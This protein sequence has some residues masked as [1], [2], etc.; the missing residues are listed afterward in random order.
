MKKTTSKKI[1]MKNQLLK[2]LKNVQL[3]FIY[4]EIDFNLHNYSLLRTKNIIKI[5]FFITFK[6]N[7]L[8]PQY[9]TPIYQLIIDITKIISTAST[10]NLKT[11]IYKYKQK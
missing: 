10:K 7:K 1:V 5:F 2:K 6:T 8:T 9:K 11:I 4:N 3:G